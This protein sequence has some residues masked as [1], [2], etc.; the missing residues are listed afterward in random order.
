LAAEPEPVIER[1]KVAVSIPEHSRQPDLEADRAK[2][3]ATDNAFA[4]KCEEKG[5]AAAFYEFLESDAKMLPTNDFAIQGRDAIR[6]YLTTVPEAVLIWK[7]S[8]ADVAGNGDMG[9]TSGTFESRTS[10]ADGHQQVVYG[11]YVSV[12]RKQL[13]GSW[14]MALEASNLSPPPVERK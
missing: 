7:P 9:Y 5:A 6:V 1:P 12:W 2:L 3:L 13:D 10:A 8:E 11:K 4:R 14:K